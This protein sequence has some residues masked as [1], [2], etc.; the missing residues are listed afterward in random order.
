MAKQTVE[1]ITEA[2]AEALTRNGQA[3]ETFM[4]H[5]ADAAVGNVSRATV[6]LTE[7]SKAS[8]AA[9]GRADQGVSGTGGKESKQAT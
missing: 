9:V 1:R 3:A 6:A 5:A 4:N 8:R 2:N 7:G